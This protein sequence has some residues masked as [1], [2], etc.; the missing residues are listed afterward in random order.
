M[1]FLS[2]SMDLGVWIPAFSTNSDGCE[3]TVLTILGLCL[4]GIGMQIPPFCANY[5]RFGAADCA[6]WVHSMDLGVWI[7]R[8]WRW[9][10]G[11][12]STVLTILELFMR[13]GGVL[14][15]RFNHSGISTESLSNR[16]NRFQFNHKSSK[17]IRNSQN[18]VNSLLHLC[19]FVTIPSKEGCRRLTRL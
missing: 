12:G 13:G 6:F 9:F 7:P 17:S 19:P 3:C 18:L 16:Q 14:G 1:G 4:R 2:H 5:W 15:C 11:Y 8:Y 10:G